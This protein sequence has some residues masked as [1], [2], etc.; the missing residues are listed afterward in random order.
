MG[1]CTA[2]HLLG[3]TTKQPWE[4][5]VTFAAERAMSFMALPSSSAS[6]T[7]AGQIRSSANVSRLDLC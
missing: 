1:M 6:Q 4:P 5:D 7:S 3:D 2:G